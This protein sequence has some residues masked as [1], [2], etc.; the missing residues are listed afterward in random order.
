MA[1]AVQETTLLDLIVELQRRGVC[2]EQELVALVTELLRTGRIRLA[3]TFRNS[4]GSL[5]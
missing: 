1:A 5:I 4:E 3:G 2:S